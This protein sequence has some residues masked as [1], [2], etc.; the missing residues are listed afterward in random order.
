MATKN[1]IGF[2]G[3]FGSLTFSLNRL[4]AR[5]ITQ[6][7]APLRL[8]DFIKMERFVLRRSKPHIFVSYPVPYTS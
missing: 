2:P 8:S 5:I 1:N 4:G 7:I 3:A 6:F